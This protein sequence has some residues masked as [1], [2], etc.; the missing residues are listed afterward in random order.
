MKSVST[1]KI[2]VIGPVLAAWAEIRVIEQSL[3]FIPHTLIFID[4]LEDFSSDENRV[5]FYNKWREKLTVLQPEYD[6]FIGFSLGGVILQENLDL[7]TDKAVLLFS[8][9]TFIDETLSNRLNAVIKLAR[10]KSVFDAIREKN[11]YVF[12]PYPVPD[13]VI[14]LTNDKIAADRLATGLEYVLGVDSRTKLQQTPTKVMHLIGE[15][16][17]LVNRDNVVAINN[18]GLVVVPNAGM[19]VLQNNPSY[20]VDAILPFLNG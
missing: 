9:P 8:S 3:G 18:G 7:L 10:E 5:D 19:R 15:Q 14:N 11:R 17:Q 12:S 16:S 20:C 2:L 1:K 13:Y 6:A 4:P